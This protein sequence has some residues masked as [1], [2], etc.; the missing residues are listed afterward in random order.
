M[1]P[2]VPVHLRPK[3]GLQNYHILWEAE[4]HPVPPTDPMLLRRYAGDLWI[5]I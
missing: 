4:W 1:V 2:I 3:H 5:G